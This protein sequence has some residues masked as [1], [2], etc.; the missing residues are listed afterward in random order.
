MCRS[1]LRRRAFLCLAA[2]FVVA[3]GLATRV[4]SIPLPALVKSYGGDTLWAVLVFLLLAIAMPRRSALSLAVVAMI[5]AFGVEVLQLYQAPWL[6]A[7]RSTL[8]GRLVLGQGFLFSDLLCYTVG[9]CLAAAIYHR[10]G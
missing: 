2:A 4:D 8:P 6:T 10:L 3:V 1:L 7:I 9:I 5:V